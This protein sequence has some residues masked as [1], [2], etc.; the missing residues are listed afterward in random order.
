MTPPSRLFQDFAA[1]HNPNETQTEQDLIRPLLELL[2][3]TDDLPQQ[4]SSGGEDIP[5]LLLFADPRPR[6][7]PAIARPTPT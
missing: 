1:Y 3:W 5:D 2:G 6:T 4:T 7:A